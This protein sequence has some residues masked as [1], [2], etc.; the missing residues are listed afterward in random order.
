MNTPLT[1]FDTANSE[2]RRMVRIGGVAALAFGI[3]YILIMALYV[4]LGAPPDGAEA[5]LIYH[6]ANIAGW[7]AILSL[8]ILTDFLLIPIAIALYIALRNANRNGMLLAAASMGLFVIL[9]L[10]L[11]WTN[12]AVMIRLSERMI[13]TTGDAQIAA[14]VAAAQY[15]TLVL[16]SSLLFIYNSL[17]LA[18]GIFITG[19]VMLQGGF[20]KI[21]AYLGIFTGILGIA[22]VVGSILWSALGVII[23]PASALTT[24]W[25]ILAG[26][27]L[28]RLS[29]A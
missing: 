10:T 27:G 26:F 3:G 2:D 9:D 1:T 4:P 6:S 15:P 8:S 7:W 14:V 13:N 19:V 28:F 18:I 21:T 22:A 5:R 16:E 11:T 23:I 29:Q 20:P 12:Y 24:I 25:T 17:T